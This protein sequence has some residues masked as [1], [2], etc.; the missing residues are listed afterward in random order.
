M[1]PN[2]IVVALLLVALTA[3]CGSAAETTVA[4][5]AEQFYAAVGSGDG[6]AACALLAPKTKSVL[7]QSAGKPCEQAILEEDIP[8]VNAPWA[9]HV[10]GRM[11]QVEFAEETTFLAEFQAGWKVMAAACAPVKARPYDCS[12]SG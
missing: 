3:G 7:E 2:R 12:V 4:D 11:G 1:R 6:G 10:F 9:S 5:V 8:R